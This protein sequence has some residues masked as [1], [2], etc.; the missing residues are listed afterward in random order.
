ML[1]AN[2]RFVICGVRFGWGVCGSKRIDGMGWDGT[3][4]CIGVGR[5]KCDISKISSLMNRGKKSRVRE[6]QKA[7]IN[8][9]QKITKKSHSSFQKNTSIN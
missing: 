4:F 6:S 3:I 7:A 2:V 5:V 9:G 1:K 8:I